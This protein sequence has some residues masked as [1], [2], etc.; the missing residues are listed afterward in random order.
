MNP[1]AIRLLNQQLICPQYN[2]STEVVHYMGAIQAQEYR[3]EMGGGYENTQS[4]RESI[5]FGI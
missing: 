5:Q 4:I 2:T 1:I 3:D